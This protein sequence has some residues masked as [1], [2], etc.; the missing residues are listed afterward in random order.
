VPLPSHTVHCLLKM[1]L[2]V[3]AAQFGLALIARPRK[4]AANISG[5]VSGRKAGHRFGLRTGPFR[6]AS[7]GNLLYN[8]A[9]W[10]SVRFRT[11]VGGDRQE[12][13]RN[14]FT[15]E[16]SRFGGTKSIRRRAKCYLSCRTRRARRLVVDH[17]GR[18]YGSVQNS[19]I[20][21]AVI[22]AGREHVI[23]SRQGA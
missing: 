23:R 15:R 11:E 13:P 21:F 6:K 7:C 20:R 19:G 17:A 1:R 3:M 14:N 5:I 10:L 2:V 9:G 8:S 12:R 16:A 4:T 22:P 18:R